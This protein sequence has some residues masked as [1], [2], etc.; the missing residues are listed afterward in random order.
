MEKEIITEE[1]QEVIK[2]EE[3]LKVEALQVKRESLKKEEVRFTDDD[4][5]I[6]IVNFKLREDRLAEYDQWD[7]DDDAEIA[8]RQAH[9]EETARLRALLDKKK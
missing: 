9:K 5:V 8:R 3:V 7:I 1:V 2:N 4:D 6:E